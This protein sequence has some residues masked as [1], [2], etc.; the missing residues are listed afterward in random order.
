MAQTRNTASKFKSIYGMNFREMVEKWGHTRQA[1][2]ELHKRG[3]LKAFLL[4]PE[5]FELERYS[6]I[7]TRYVRA[8]GMKQKELLKFLNLRL[9]STLTDLDRAGLLHSC[10]ASV[11]H[12]IS[13]SKGKT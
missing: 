12:R 5:K 7:N 1:Y 11:R 10:I 9:Q 8:Y 2:H 4:D 3:R 6:K 13:N